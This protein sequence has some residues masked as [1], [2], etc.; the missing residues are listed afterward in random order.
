MKQFCSPLFH[1]SYFFKIASSSKELT[2]VG[3]SVK[4]LHVDIKESSIYCGYDQ[5]FPF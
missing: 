3:R 4:L 1:Y 5:C 2:V